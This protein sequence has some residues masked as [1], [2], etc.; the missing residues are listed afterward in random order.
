MH[1][2][3]QLDK[4]ENGSKIKT[5]GKGKHH[6]R[7]PRKL[8]IEW[9]VIIAGKKDTFV[10]IVRNLGVKTQTRTVQHRRNQQ[11]G[12]RGEFVVNAVEST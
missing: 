6:S 7:L 10:E 1:V 3:A 2:Q 12:V 8:V 4:L 5:G 9:F 11:M